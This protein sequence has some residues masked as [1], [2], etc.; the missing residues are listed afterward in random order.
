MRKKI[1]EKKRE[2][3]DFD[4]SYFY[5]KNIHFNVNGFVSEKKV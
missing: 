3:K 1:V 2:Q 4:F 5:H